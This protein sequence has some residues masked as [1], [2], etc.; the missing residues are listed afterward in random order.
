MV[1]SRRN[2]I[3]A[4]GI[5]I[6]TIM[7]GNLAGCNPK[8]TKISKDKLSL[9][10]YGL[11]GSENK[12]V[13]IYRVHREDEQKYTGV[14]LEINNEFIETKKEPLEYQKYEEALGEMILKHQIRH[15][16]SII[17]YFYEAY[18]EKSEYTAEEISSVLETLKAKNQELDYSKEKTSRQR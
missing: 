12:D 9:Y 18:G 11:C 8:E 13:I 5:T 16:D 6:G 15:H 4:V 7:V 10:E 3:K 17:E 14:L 1:L 2:F